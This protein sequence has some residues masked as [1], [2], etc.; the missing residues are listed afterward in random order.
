MDDGAAMDG[1]VDGTEGRAIDGR[2]M[3]GRAMDGRA[4][5]GGIIDGRAIDDRATEGRAMDGRTMLLT[6]SFESSVSGF[7]PFD[8]AVASR[9]C[10]R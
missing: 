10:F 4:I 6:V 8:G 3:D 9:R 2:A 1:R 5:D 7:L